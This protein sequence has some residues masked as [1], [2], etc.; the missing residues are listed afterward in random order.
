MDIFE[1]IKQC[2][3][4]GVPC[5]KLSE[6]ADVSNG[7]QFDKIDI[8]KDGI[9]PVMNGDIFPLDYSNKYNQDANTVIISQNGFSAGY[10][11]W[12]TIPFWAG[13]HCYVLKS[14]VVFNK[15]LYYVLK[16]NEYILQSYYQDFGI[17]FLPKSVLLNLSIPVP[18]FN[19]QQEIVNVLDKCDTY[20]NNK[21]ADLVIKLVICKEQFDYYCNKLLNFDD[22]VERKFLGEVVNILNNSHKSILKSNEI[23]GLYP[24]YGSNGVQ[25]YVSKYLLD[26]T[27]LLVSKDNNIISNDVYPFVIWATGKFCFNNHVYVISEKQDLSLRYLF[28]YLQRIS[29]SKCVKNDVFKFTL[30]DLKSIV[31]PV[32]SFDVQQNI[33]SIL[34]K[35]QELEKRLEKEIEMHNQQYEYDRDKLL[36]FSEKIS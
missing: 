12:M 29:V 15:Y 25:D 21:V 31:I 36:D 11:N 10:V 34:D 1:L 6:V 14:S 8:Q 33:V 4:D 28:Y 19:V 30:S 7:V 17:K 24:Y 26:G 3:P 18:P 20:C 32:P 27:Y 13:V 35:F 16:T 22:T 5:K 9:Y 23:S 2:C